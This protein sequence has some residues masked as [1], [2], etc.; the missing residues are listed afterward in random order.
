MQQ[1][2]HLFIVLT[3]AMLIL[4]NAS[5]TLLAEPVNIVRTDDHGWETS[6]WLGHG[7]AEVVGPVEPDNIAASNNNKILF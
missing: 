6:L 3:P 5:A 2:G 1:F 4:T 7:Q